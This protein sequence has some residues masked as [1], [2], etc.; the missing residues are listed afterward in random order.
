LVSITRAVELDKLTW[1]SMPDKE[2]CQMVKQAPDNI[3]KGADGADMDSI[4]Y[5]KEWMVRVK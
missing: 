5:P 1:V 2:T 3:T 4:I